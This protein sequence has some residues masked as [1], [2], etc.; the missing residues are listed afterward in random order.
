MD[1]K[2]KKAKCVEDNYEAIVS[3]LDGLDPLVLDIIKNAL[4]RCYAE[5]RIEGVMEGWDKGY[6]LGYHDKRYTEH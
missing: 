4:A 1:A 6:D 2:E 5:G 3:L